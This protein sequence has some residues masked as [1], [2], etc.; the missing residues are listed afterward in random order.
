VHAQ[1]NAIEGNLNPGPNPNL[2]LFYP[3]PQPN[4]KPKTNS[5]GA[6]PLFI[7][8][9]EAKKGEQAEGSRLNGNP[10]GTEAVGSEYTGDGTLQAGRQ[11]VVMNLPQA[12]RRCVGRR[13]RA[14]ARERAVQTER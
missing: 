11:V 7:S 3:Y 4:P 13:L 6:N 2:L 8:L 12:L 5:T 14:R 9:N 1:P 10:G